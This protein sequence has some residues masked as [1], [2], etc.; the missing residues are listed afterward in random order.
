MAKP[1]GNQP[2]RY[3]TI[4]NIPISKEEMAIITDQGLIKGIDDNGFIIFDK[5]ELSGS[6]VYWSNL[7]EIRKTDDYTGIQL[8][9]KN[10][11]DEVLPNTYANWDELM[12]SIPEDFGDFNSLKLGFTTTE[13]TS[14][15]TDF[16]ELIGIDYDEAKE[17]VSEIN[18]MREAFMGEETPEEKSDYEEVVEEEEEPTI[19]PEPVIPIKAEEEEDARYEV[20]E[21]QTSTSLSDKELL[22]KI[23]A[24][25]TGSQ[26]ASENL[27]Y[28]KTENELTSN[29]T[30]K[31]NAQIQNMT[32]LGF[33]V[34]V[35]QETHQIDFG[36][37]SDA[38][39]SESGDSIIFEHRNGKTLTFPQSVQGWMT[40]IQKMPFRFRSFDRK[41]MLAMVNENK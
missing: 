29:V 9:Y 14:D 19:E 33:D 6:H 3:P 17:M 31:A 37:F 40:M 7:R 21:Y 35:N 23:L 36:K 27:R 41:K 32:S 34:Q 20:K 4:Y 10:L 38:Y 18:Q 24:E 26:Y 25:A 12:E 11:S 16:D 28:Q 5:D 22:A 8:I 13:Y 15:T 30:F 2:L 39:F 1:Q